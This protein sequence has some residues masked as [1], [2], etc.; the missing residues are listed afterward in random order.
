MLLSLSY[1]AIH[2]EPPS[3]TDSKR[4]DSQQKTAFTILIVDFHSKK[5]GIQELYYFVDGLSY[6]EKLHLKFNY[7]YKD[8]L[9]SALLTYTL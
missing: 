3:Y 4:K 9:Y 5:Y 6:T 2:I 8:K 1:N 7:L